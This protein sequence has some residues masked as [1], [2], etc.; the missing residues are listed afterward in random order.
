MTIYIALQGGL[1]N[2]LFQYAAAY[3]LSKT[4]EVKI[5]KADFAHSGR[6]YRKS[7]Y[8][9]VSSVETP[10]Q[11]PLIQLGAFVAWTPED[12]C[13]LENTVIRGYFQYLPAIETIIPEIRQ[14]VL[15]FLAPYKEEIRSKYK[16]ENLS[17]W[18]FSM[19]GG[20]TI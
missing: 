16:I 3:Q 4:G 14:D 7:L 20:E 5:I 19:C 17:L 12:Y 10:P 2:Q 11:A 15:S 1:G 9:R 13:R 6:D 18:D 8:Y